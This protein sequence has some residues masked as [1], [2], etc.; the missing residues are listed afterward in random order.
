MRERKRA[1]VTQTR[2]DTPGRDYY[3]RKIAEGKTRPEPAS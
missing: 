2:F 3:Q 1:T